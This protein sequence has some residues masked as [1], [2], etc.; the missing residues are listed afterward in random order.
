M[1]IYRHPDQALIMAPAREESSSRADKDVNGASSESNGS[2]TQQE[3]SSAR[4]KKKLIPFLDHFNARDLKVLFRCSVAFW[5]ASLFIFI[6]PVLKNFGQATFFGCISVLFLPPNGVVSVFLL[7]GFT[8]VLGMALGWAW[9]VIAQ[10]AAIATRSTA[11][12]NARLQQLGRTAQAT[13]TPA[14]VLVFN[15]FM[16]DTRVTVTYFCMLGLFIYLMV[17]SYTGYL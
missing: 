10:K 12:T 17:I 4:P 7:G 6:N 11:E 3:A 8:E 14:T 2:V 5:V 1:L 9:G 13:A 16:L 15:G